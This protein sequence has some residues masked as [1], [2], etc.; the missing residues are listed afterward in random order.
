M[1]L[2]IAVFLFSIGSSASV[3]NSQD[4]REL[5]FNQLQKLRY[6]YI[7]FL[8]GVEKDYPDEVS[9][10][11][12]SWGIMKSAYAN[13][14][15]LCFFG[16]WPSKYEGKYCRA[17]WKRKD[18]QLVKQYGGYQPSSACG[19]PDEFR[20]NPT[21]FGKPSGEKNGVQEVN[22]VQVNFSPAKNQDAGYCVKT[23]GTYKNLTQKCEQAS[24]DSINDVINSYEENPEELDKF[25]KAIAD[26]CKMKP[27]YDA[28]DDLAKRV[29]DITGKDIGEF[30]STP[31]NLER[32]PSSGPEGYGNHVLNKC[33]DYINK[34]DLDDDRGLFN[35]LK[36]EHYECV[37]QKL[38]T[39][40]DKSDFKALAEQMEK[41]DALTQANKISLENSLKALLAS[42]IKFNSD[43]INLDLKNKDKFYASL[44]QKYPGLDDIYK[45]VVDKVYEDLDGAIKSGTLLPLDKTSV[46]DQFNQLANEVNA[47]CKEIYDKFNG[48]RSYLNRNWGWYRRTFAN[49]EEEEFYKTHKATVENKVKN[50]FENSEIAHLMGTDRFKKKVMDPSDRFVEECAVNETYQVVQ[51]PLS[52]ST[53]DEAHAELDDKL[54][55]NVDLNN[56][57]AL[58][59]QKGK[60]VDIKG[61]YRKIVKQDP[62]A[63]IAAIELADSDDQAG[64]AAHMCTE[65]IDIYKTDRAWN[66]VQ[67]GVAGIGTVAGG[68]LIASGLGAPVGAALITASTSLVTGAA[69][70]EGAMAYD[71]YMDAKM[72]ERG[73]DNTIMERRNNIDDYLS[74]SRQINGQKVNAY[75]QGGLSVVGLIPGLQAIRGGG[76]TIKNTAKVGGL[77]LGNADET[78]EVVIRGT[79]SLVLANTDEATEL[80]IRGAQT[81]STGS[82]TAGNAG[83]TISSTT[84]KAASGVNSLVDDVADIMQD[85]VVYTSKNMDDI[86]RTTDLAKLPS[87]VMV[88]TFGKSKASLWNKALKNKLTKGDAQKFFKQMAEAL[89][90][91]NMPPKKVYRLM[92]TKLHGD[93]L[94]DAGQAIQKLGDTESQLLS[95]MWDLIK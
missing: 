78:G 12:D 32:A 91:P 74:R 87:E 64:M 3:L 22:G 41:S 19:A 73:V 56:E 11:F 66:W 67:W 58:L 57:N 51:S 46:K 15:T 53:I 8:Y 42:Q 30:K 82:N 95:G 26:F 52:Q 62:T 39:L 69:V 80:A 40:D 10:L 85:A 50:L 7:Q 61:A 63:M 47:A 93:K 76:K 38:Q 45:D 31:G 35:I 36:N 70:V 16:G 75:I 49:D 94:T 29:K 83:R 79:N 14:G 17:P 88:E 2:L 44:K 13:D 71:N 81:G 68:V 18:D 6:S 21:L 86:K 37:P 28:C 5:N 55:E 89:G 9:S 60:T 43:K 90:D 33:K 84:N 24:R 4:I 27:D 25:T 54:K 92:Q 59:V 23:N 34:K 65:V 1:R 77:I 20:C 48:S 72:R